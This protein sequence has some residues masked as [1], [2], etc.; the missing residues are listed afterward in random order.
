ML[1]HKLEGLLPTALLWL[2]APILPRCLSD[3]HV[4]YCAGHLMPPL[5]L[6]VYKAAPG[7]ETYSAVLSALRIGY[8]HIDTAQVP[9]GL[10]AVPAC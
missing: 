6:G 2:L 7:E 5:G 10:P 8:R 3:L 9:R 1:Q 4:L